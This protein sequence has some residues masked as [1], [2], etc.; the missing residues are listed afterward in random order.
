MTEIVELIGVGKTYPE[1]GTEKIHV[2]KNVSFRL[3]P[4][5]SLGIVGESGSGKTTVARM[6]TGLLPPS[7]GKILIGGVQQTGSPATRQQRLSIAKLGQMVFQDPYSSL[8]PRQSLQGCLDEVLK[9]HSSNGKGERSDKIDELLDAVGLDVSFRKRMPYE[10]SGGQRQRIAIARALAVSPEFIVLDEAVSALDVSVQAQIL[11]LLND[12]RE[13]L[14]ISY[15][16]ISHDLAVIR[17]IADNVIVMRQG[18]VVE[19]GTTDDILRDR[20]SVV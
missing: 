12:L 8:D 4:N 16:F 20:K 3:G 11:N 6:V 15:L 18:T 14:G 19:E 1:T 9:L 2:V 7:S 17:N 13:S 10:L 5:Q